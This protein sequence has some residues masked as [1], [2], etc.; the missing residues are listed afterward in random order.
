MG[1]WDLARLGLYAAFAAGSALSL[2]GLADF[3]PQSGLLDL[4][5]LNV[6]AL[7]GATSGIGAGG[8][9]AF[10]LLKRWGGR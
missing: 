8:L 9:A 1:K 6:Y 7:V 5:P 3:D 4:R 10:A 2:T